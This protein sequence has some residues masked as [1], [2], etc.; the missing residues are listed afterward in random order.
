LNRSIAELS[1]IPVVVTNQVRS[2]SN[3][4]GYHFPFE[5]FDIPLI[6]AIYSQYVVELD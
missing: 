1:R 2:Q 5:G 3:D 4:E 6:K